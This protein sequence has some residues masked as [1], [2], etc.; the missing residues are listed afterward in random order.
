M[1]LDGQVRAARAVAI[2][3]MSRTMGHG[4]DGGYTGS[5]AMLRCV[6]EIFGITLAIL[7]LAL[8]V[9]L[10]SAY[11][12][13]SQAQTPDPSSAQ[14]HH[15]PPED[16]PIHERFYSTWMMPD[17]PTAS[18]CNNRDC[19]PTEVRYRNGFWEAKRREDGVYVR[20]PWEKV[21]Q[22]RDNPDGRSHVCMPPPSGY[23]GDEVY[24]FTLGGGT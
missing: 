10:L 24:C 23:H 18:C 3:A 14:A 5:G 17:K 7:G 11:F 15:H 22:N 2:T 16:V 4:F 9:L 1:T 20:I 13:L 12:D 21:E 6:L 8:A 19:Y